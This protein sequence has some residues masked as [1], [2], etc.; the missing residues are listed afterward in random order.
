VLL[1]STRRKLGQPPKTRPAWLVGQEDAPI[2]AVQKNASARRTRVGR[3]CGRKTSAS[4]SRSRLASS[5][6]DSSGV[7]AAQ[8]WEGTDGSGCFSE[9][10]FEIQLRTWPHE[11]LA[12]SRV[13]TSVRLGLPDAASPV[14]RFPAGRHGRVVRAEIKL[15]LEKARASLY[16]L[17]QPQQ[18]P[19]GLQA[20]SSRKCCGFL[21]ADGSS[22]HRSVVPQLREW[23]D[24]PVTG[25]RQHALC[26]FAL[27]LCRGG[28]Q[29]GRP[30]AVDVDR[31]SPRGSQPRLGSCARR[32]V[33]GRCEEDVEKGEG[34][35]LTR[36]RWGGSS[37]SSSG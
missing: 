33:T 31:R 5:S 2:G 4:L 28:V 17:Q 23:M 16:F 7:N 35:R 21:S 30:P 11:R 26:L 12:T 8:R 34:R 37:G 24:A 29:V 32:D 1:F 6:C 15:F 27:W 19:Q 18:G 14:A 9:S 13:N 36:R 10:R 25:V 22:P 3:L 20:Q